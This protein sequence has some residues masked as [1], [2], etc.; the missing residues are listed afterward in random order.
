MKH[1]DCSG[2]FIQDHSVKYEVKCISRKMVEVPR[3]ICNK[4]SMELFE[5]TMDFDPDNKK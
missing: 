3:L 4:C 1:E 5:T 2:E